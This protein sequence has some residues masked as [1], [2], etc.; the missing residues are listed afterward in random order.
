MHH[1]NTANHRVINTLMKQ[2]KI[3]VVGAGAA[4]FITAAAIKRNNPDILVDIVYDPLAPTV[5]VGES[6]GF[7]AKTFF[8]STLGMNEEDWMVQTGAV[9][10]YGAILTGWD[11]TDAAV[12]LSKGKVPHEYKGYDLLDL[13]VHAYNTGILTRDKFN[14]IYD[15]TGREQDIHT[16]I[17]YRKTYHID[18]TKMGPIV[19]SLVGIPAGVTETKIPVKVAVTEDGVNIDHLVLKDDSIYTADLYIDCTGFSRVLSKELP[20]KFEGCGYQYNNTTIVGPSQYNNEHKFKPWS[21]LRTMD[22]GWAFN[23]SL[24]QR[25]GNGYIFNSN[26]V[27]DES[28]LVEEFES[29]TGLKNVIS[30]RIAWDPGYYDKAMIGNCVTIGLGFGMIDAYDANVFSST[31]KFIGELVRHLQVDQARDLGWRDDFN[32][33]VTAAAESIKLRIDAAFH[34]APKNDTP[35]WRRMKEVGVERNTLGRL[36]ELMS[37]E[38][39]RQLSHEHNSKLDYFRFCIY[40][41]LDVKFPP[42][43]M[44]G[45]EYKTKIAIESLTL[46]SDAL[47]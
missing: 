47:Q 17:G 41:N 46:F 12:T 1:I 5:G 20:F 2:Y 38:R 26:F 35:Y 39:Y 15:I 16:R 31:L 25:S 37:S 10:K 24:A 7:I 22:D 32:S 34:L 44:P 43:L 11:G 30:K 29:K 33:Y 18:A 8:Y 4:G 9:D 19:H 23:V 28:K 27:T 14:F 3:A 42:P 6:L 45:S 21:S 40:Y 13:W 36:N